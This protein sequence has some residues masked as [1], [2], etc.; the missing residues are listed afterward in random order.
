MAKHYA[1]E[2]GS[3]LIDKPS[4]RRIEPVKKPTTGQNA[5]KFQ[6]GT[7]VSDKL[8]S[9]ADQIAILKPHRI[10]TYDMSK[11]VRKDGATV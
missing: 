4:I 6:I 2:R 1:A 3:R 7:W 5:D 8:C 9:N 11:V 10:N